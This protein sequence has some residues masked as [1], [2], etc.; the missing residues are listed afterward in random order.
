MKKKTTYDEQ[1]KNY[2]QYFYCFGNDQVKSE[3]IL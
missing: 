1:N 2:A 3:R